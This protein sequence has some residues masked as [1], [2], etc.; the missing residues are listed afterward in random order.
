MM[1]AYGFQTNWIFIFG[2]HKRTKWMLNALV[3]IFNG[4]HFRKMCAFTNFLLKINMHCF[5]SR[6]KS[7][8][9]SKSVMFSFL[10]LF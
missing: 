9:I 6:C 1:Q 8:K 4:V 10:I 2:N 5:S 3:L 7:F